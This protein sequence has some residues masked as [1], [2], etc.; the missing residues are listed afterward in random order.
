MGD[1][2][3]GF[4]TPTQIDTLIDVSKFKESLVGL[5]LSL[6]LRDFNRFLALKLL[7][8]S[9][10]RI[11]FDCQFKHCGQQMFFKCE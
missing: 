7:I 2:A 4:V 11:C 5:E 6:E 3:Q 9:H 8:I 10:D 1:H